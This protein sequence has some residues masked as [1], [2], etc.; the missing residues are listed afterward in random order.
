MIGRARQRILVIE[1]EV[2]IALMLQR[3]LEGLGYHI[4][5]SPVCL[6]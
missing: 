4:A 5:V 2:L 3:M 6:C 1:D